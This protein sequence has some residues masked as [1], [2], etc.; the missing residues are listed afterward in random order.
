M[1]VEEEVEE[2][3]DS[4]V[5]VYQTRPG[6]TVRSISMAFGMSLDNFRHLNP[7][8]ATDAFEDGEEVAVYETRTVTTKEGDGERLHMHSHAFL[9]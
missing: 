4:R 6:D 9:V 5:D 7:P 2:D 8:V 3:V 1:T